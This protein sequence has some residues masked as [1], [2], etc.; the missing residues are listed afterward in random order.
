MKI[1]D[2]VKVAKEILSRYGYWPEVN[3]ARVKLAGRTGYI[4]AEHNA[5]GLCYDVKIGKEIASFDPDEL[6]VLE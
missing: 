5:H 6:T 3:V 1:K 4:I 2:K